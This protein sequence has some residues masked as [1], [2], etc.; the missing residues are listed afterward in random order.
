MNSRSRNFLKRIVIL[1]YHGTPNYDP[2]SIHSIRADLFREHLH[3]L[4]KHGWH[5]ALFKE[6]SDTGALPEKTVVLTF[7]DGYADNYEG[8]FRRLADNNMKATWF[9]TTD[10]IGKYS[11]LMGEM[12]PL[13]L[14]LSAEQLIEMEN[15]G[16]E[17]GSHT[18]SHPDLTMLSYQ[19]QLMEMNESKQ[20][21]ESIIQKEVSTFSYPYGRHNADSVAAA[22]EAGYKQACIV[23]PNECGKQANP[24]VFKRVPIQADDS[25]KAL[26]RKLILP[27]VYYLPPK[28]KMVM[29]IYQRINHK[30]IV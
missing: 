5:T 21:L 19:Q 1:M 22:N 8:A 6:L 2:P 24:F 15:A 28:R 7:D 9:I 30:L 4:K 16:M 26:A 3:Y 27:Q 18:C 29:N 25:V 14:M 13:T 17:I 11:R 20:V 10:Y 12:T 23:S